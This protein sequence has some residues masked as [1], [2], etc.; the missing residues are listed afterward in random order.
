MIIISVKETDWSAPALGQVR[1][2]VDPDLIFLN[3][4]KINRLNNQWMNNDNKTLGFCQRLPLWESIETIDN[5][6]N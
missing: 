2:S 4:T 5:R 1:I 6:S 3:D